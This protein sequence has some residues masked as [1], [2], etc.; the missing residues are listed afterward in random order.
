MTKR[1]FALRLRRLAR[2]PKGLLT[3]ALLGLAAMGVPSNDLGQTVPAIVEAVLGATVVDAGLM[4]LRKGIVIVPDSA[5]VSGLIVA[6]VLSPGQAWY[7][8]VATGATAVVS[9]HL[10]RVPQ[11]HLFNPAAAALVLC[12]FV[13]PT[14]QNWWGALPDLSVP[15]I[16]VLIALGL[17][18]VTR[19]S[20]LPQVLA[21]LLTYFVVLTLAAAVPVMD[22]A[23]IAAAFR[24][25]FLNATLF[26]AFFM[27][28]DPATAPR[29]ARAQATFGVL[30]GAVGALALLLN[31]GLSFL[32][33]GLLVG[34]A[35]Y[36]V[37][38]AN[39]QGIGV[40]RRSGSS[41]WPARQ[42]AKDLEGQT[43]TPREILALGYFPSQVG[44][45]EITS[46]CDHALDL[47]LAKRAPGPDG[48]THFR[49]PGDRARPQLPWG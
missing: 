25:P 17:M 45:D 41:T 47:G 11:Y 16:A 33:I 42:L 8:P 10:L 31:A 22:A 5:L 7:V 2:S 19:V 9:R 37:R 38:R 49:L 48:L 4:Y 3:I 29:E 12:T 36:G 27:L 30:V 23:R 14:G 46:I 18:V 21:F 20:R 32:L 13:F 34:N 35:W 44:L 40:S 43:L 24:I 6:L 1:G 28:T 26:F 15:G 39:A